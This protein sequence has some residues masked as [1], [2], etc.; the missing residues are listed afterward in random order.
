MHFF[1]IVC[2][3]FRKITKQQFPT[4]YS[5]SVVIKKLITKQLKW[6]VFILFQFFLR[7]DM[8]SGQTDRQI[9]VAIYYALVIRGLFYFYFFQL[10]T[11]LN[12]LHVFHVLL[13]L[14]NL[15]LFC[16][17]I[18]LAAVISLTAWCLVLLFLCILPITICCLI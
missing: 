3:V 2:L 14:G 5:L 15:K 13:Q 9:I 11:I 18:C 17:C 8:C 12:F 16:F 4:T 10:L 7:L 1:H 6:L